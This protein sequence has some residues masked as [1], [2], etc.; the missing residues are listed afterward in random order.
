[1]LFD[2]SSYPIREAVVE[3]NNVEEGLEEG[4]ELFCLSLSSLCS[5]LS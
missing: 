2:R 1:M 4:K 3:K 5:H